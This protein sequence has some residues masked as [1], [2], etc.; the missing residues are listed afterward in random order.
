MKLGTLYG[1]GVGVGDPEWL[2]VK[3]VRLLG[4]CR[5]VC[6]PRA[7]AAADSTALEAAKPY[8]R[9]DAEVHPITFPMSADRSVLEEGW[10]KA[11]E[12]VLALLTRGED[13]CFLTLGDASLYSTY[14]YLLRA[15]KRLAPDAPTVTVPGITAFSAC[16][17]L[18]QFPIGEGKQLV[19]IVPGSDD[20]AEFA[21]SLDRGGTVVLM[22]VG[23][24]LQRVL[25]ELDARGL[26]ER[27]VFVS[28]AG[29]PEQRIETDLRRLLGADEKTG[30][31]SLLIIQAGDGAEGRR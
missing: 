24:R 16:A 18:T 11:A 6:V 5:H 3:A 19:T 15:L 26:L 25:Q 28:H 4:A 20:F 21:A 12:E 13:V 8:L 7:R 10:R 9:A 27:A 22:K 29:L 2:T 23:E 1:I 17:A 14:I 31:L 30:Y